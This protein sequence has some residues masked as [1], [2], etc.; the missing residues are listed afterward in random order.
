MAHKPFHGRATHGIVDAIR[1]LQVQNEIDAKR[2][3]ALGSWDSLI[4][5]LVGR[6]VHEKM[7]ISYA[8]LN[9][10]YA[11]AVMLK[12]SLLEFMIIQMKQ[13]AI[14]HQLI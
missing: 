5:H 1:E 12:T 3:R 14:K 6:P 8:R 9:S 13:S 11:A 10:Q 2:G 7:E 4:N